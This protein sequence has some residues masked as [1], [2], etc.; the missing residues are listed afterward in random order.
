MPPTLKPVVTY[1]QFY[2]SSYRASLHHSDSHTY[3]YIY[4]YSSLFHDCTPSPSFQV[5]FLRMEGGWK[6]NC[7]QFMTTC[8]ASSYGRL[9]PRYR[10]RRWIFLYSREARSVHENKRVHGSF[11]W[12]HFWKILSFNARCYPV[13]NVASKYVGGGWSEWR[14]WEEGIF[15]YTM[16]ICSYFQAGILDNRDWEI[17][18]PGRR[19]RFSKGFLGMVDSRRFVT[20]IIELR[21]HSRRDLESKDRGELISSPRIYILLILVSICFLDYFLSFLFYSWRVLRRFMKRNVIFNSDKWW[22][23][24]SKCIP[25]IHSYI[26]II[27]NTYHSHD[28]RKILSK[29]S[30][31][32]PNKI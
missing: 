31:P 5:F 2:P 32:F 16:K 8:R 3:T 19:S 27:I 23:F 9:M 21:M 28:E 15:L 18:V 13:I 1:K 20:R 30:I 22:L 14:V 10:K 11:R 6:R 26:N 12:V 17:A 25:C 29:F 4:V 24:Y 7:L